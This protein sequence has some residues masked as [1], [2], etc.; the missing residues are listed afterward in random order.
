MN[1]YL[2]AFPVKLQYKSYINLILIGVWADLLIR[3]IK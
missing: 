3:K 2:I 1:F